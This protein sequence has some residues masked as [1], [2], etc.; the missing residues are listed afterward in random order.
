MK[1]IFILLCVLIT[2]C[3]NDRPW[4]VIQVTEENKMCKYILSR[5]NG[6]GPQLK[7]VIDTCGKYQWNQIIQNK[8]L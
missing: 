8:D 6:L 5:S 1:K 2:S 3:K 7:E 4:R